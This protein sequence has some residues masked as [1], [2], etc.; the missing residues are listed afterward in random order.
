MLQHVGL[1]TW[2]LVLIDVEG[3]WIRDELAS[4]EDAESV[5]GELGLRLHRGWDDPRLSRRMIARDHWN[6]PGGQRRPQ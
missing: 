1:R 3:N 4:P 2:D 5:C 6:A